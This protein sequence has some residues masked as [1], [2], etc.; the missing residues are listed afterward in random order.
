MGIYFRQVAKY[1]ACERELARRFF[2][3]FIFIYLARVW[4]AMSEQATVGLCYLMTLTVILHCLLYY[5]C[6]CSTRWAD[7]KLITTT[8]SVLIM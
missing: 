2:I 3:E 7:L 1:C 4:N 6:L 5:D 8:S